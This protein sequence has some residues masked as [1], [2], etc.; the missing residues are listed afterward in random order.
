[1]TLVFYIDAEIHKQNEEKL[2]ERQ[3]RTMAAR[4]SPS[5]TPSSASTM[6]EPPVMLTEARENPDERSLASL[7]K[8]SESTAQKTPRG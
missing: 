1:M 6:G 8:K 4:R 5:P 2:A 7:R 3:R